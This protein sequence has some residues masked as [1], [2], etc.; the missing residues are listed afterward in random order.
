MALI[1]L[2][3]TKSTSSNDSI[4]GYLYWRF[5]NNSFHVHSSVSELDLIWS[6]N[7]L[8][9]R[10]QSA[11]IIK[12]NIII[13]NLL[14]FNTLLVWLLKN[15]I[16]VRFKVLVILFYF[17]KLAINNN[18]VG[19]VYKLFFDYRHKNLLTGTKKLDT[20]KRT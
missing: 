5:I 14:V 18:V 12:F 11:Y 10:E 19:K 17:F 1:P 13:V 16:I 4:R 9:S 3:C 8:I 6:S 2:N 15:T 7:S 20:V